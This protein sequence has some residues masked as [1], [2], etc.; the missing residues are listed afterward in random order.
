[1][2]LIDTIEQIAAGLEE[3]K[4]EAFFRKNASITNAILSSGPDN[5]VYHS[6][7][8]YIRRSGNDLDLDFNRYAIQKAEERQ[9]H[10]VLGHRLSLEVNRELQ[11]TMP[12]HISVDHLRIDFMSMGLAKGSPLKRSFD[13]M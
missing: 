8:K 12:L 11:A 10:I 4:Y 13:S 6:I 1:M 9:N 5:P 3:R 7:A 2:S